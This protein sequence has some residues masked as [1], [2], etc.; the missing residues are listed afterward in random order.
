VA[1]DPLLNQSYR[2]WYRGHHWQGLVEVVPWE[3]DCQIHHQSD[4]CWSAKKKALKR[5][6]E[7]EGGRRREGEKEEVR[8]EEEKEEVR[9]EEEKEEGDWE[10]EGGEGRGRIQ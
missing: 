8:E 6:K 5:E 10:G 3:G 1:G 9:E 4:V 2:G 7:G